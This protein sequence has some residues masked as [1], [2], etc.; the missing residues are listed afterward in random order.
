MAHFARALLISRAPLP[1]LDGDGRSPIATAGRSDR[2]ATPAH[3]TQ[4]GNVSTF[5]GKGDGTLVPASQ[6]PLAVQNS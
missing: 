1:E 3:Q 2:R 5:L 6:N 4:I